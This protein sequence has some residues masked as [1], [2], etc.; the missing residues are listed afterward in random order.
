MGRGLGQFCGR[1]SRIFPKTVP[2]WTCHLTVFDVLLDISGGG[3]G[4]G[5][6]MGGGSQ[7][8]EG[9]SRAQNE[10][11]APYA[12]EVEIVNGAIRELALAVW[13][14]KHG[15]KSRVVA[16]VRHD[17][18]RHEVTRRHALKLQRLLRCR[19]SELRIVFLSPMW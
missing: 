18:H 16:R 13:V 6:K 12:A 8:L 1:M 10:L 14:V 3:P 17:R 7:R 11:L 15:L 4:S 2:G 19:D 5:L 9:V